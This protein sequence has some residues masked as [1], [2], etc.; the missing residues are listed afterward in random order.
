[1]R[2]FLFFILVINLSFSQQND[3]FVGAN[4]K[5]N[6]LDFIGAIE[7]YNELLIVGFHFM[8]PCFTSKWNRQKEMKLLFTNSTVIR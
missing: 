8:L 3:V 7:K 5:Y 6:S 2:H 4:E 1:M